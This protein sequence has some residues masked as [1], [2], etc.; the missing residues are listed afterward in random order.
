M[1]FDRFTVRSSPVGGSVRGYVH[2]T[3]GGSFIVAS[4]GP[5]ADNTVVFSSM[6]TITYSSDPSQLGL[7]VNT[8]SGWTDGF[9]HMVAGRTFTVEAY[10]LLGA[11]TSTDPY[12]QSAQGYFLYAP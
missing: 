10:S 6:C 3:A 7:V 8:L 12:N 4:F 5:V 9:W 2:W 11:G 1:D